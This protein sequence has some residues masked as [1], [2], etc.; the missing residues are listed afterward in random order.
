V[1]EIS[2]VGRL[3]RR[4]TRHTPG[5][6]RSLVEE[7]DKT[8]SMCKPGGRLSLGGMLLNVAQDA[9]VNL[10]K[11]RMLKVRGQSALDSRGYP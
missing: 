4:N 2:H 3:T 7:D 8:Q 5:Y 9:P 11:E 6:L 10:A 1:L